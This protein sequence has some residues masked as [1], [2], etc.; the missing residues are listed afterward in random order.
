MP[1]IF[2][3]FT[4]IWGALCSVNQA[5]QLASGAVVVFLDMIGLIGYAATVTA[6]TKNQ[7]ITVTVTHPP[8]WMTAA[9]T[10]TLGTD[11]SAALPFYALT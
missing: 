7:S 11:G 6:V 2:S 1:P 4:K 3:Q 9:Q 10:F 5:N 8:A